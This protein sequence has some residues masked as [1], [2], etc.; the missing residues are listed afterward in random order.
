M[1]D[2]LFASGKKHEVISNVYQGV[3]SIISHVIKKINERNDIMDSVAMLPTPELASL[4][5]SL[6]NITS[7]LRKVKIDELNATVGGPI[8]VFVISK[9]DGLVW[10]K[11]KNCLC[12]EDIT[13]Y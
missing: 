8:D 13:Q 7:I 3:C 4:A 11:K 10:M 2:S 9:R 6:I 12:N 1:D 5:E